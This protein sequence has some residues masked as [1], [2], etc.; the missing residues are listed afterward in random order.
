MTS[1]VSLID[2]GYL[3]SDDNVHVV[4]TQYLFDRMSL[5]LITSAGDIILWNVT[6]EEV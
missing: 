4:S 6:S 1:Q 5:C 2:S 3:S